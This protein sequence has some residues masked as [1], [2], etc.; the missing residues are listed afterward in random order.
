MARLARRDDHGPF[1]GE[2][3]VRPLRPRSIAAR[4][5]NLLQ[6]AATLV[7]HGRDPASIRGLADLVERPAFETILTHYWQRTI[8]ARIARNELRSG[9]ALPREAGV[10]TQTGAIASALMLVARHHC[11][12]PGH[13]IETLADLARDLHPPAQSGINAATR[14]LLNALSVPA[15]RNRLLRLPHRLMREAKDLRSTRPLEA[16]RLAMIAT[17]I[18]FELTIPLRITNLATLQIGVHLKRLDPRTGLISLLAIQADAMKNGQL[19]EM[20]IMAET[21]RFLEAYITDWRP[22]LHPG[23]DVFLFPAGQGDRSGARSVDTLRKGIVGAIAEHV[24]VAMRVH[25]F[26]AFAVMLLLEDQPGALEDA[27]LLLGHKTMRT[28]ERFYTWIKPAHA[29]SRYQAALSRARQ[30]ASTALLTTTRVTT[31]RRRK[32]AVKA[33]DQDQ[34]RHPPARDRTRRQSPEPGS[35]R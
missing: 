31:P 15:T 29:S 32:A 6:A 17:A 4:R 27:R 35:S 18:E 2:G 13:V 22:L 33:A 11:H 20:P 26:R 8:D 23:D 24:G 25:D 19:L 14:A 5:F 34:S 30:G 1:R 3:P 10:S 21:G 28:A 9:D 7:I 12:L 16:G